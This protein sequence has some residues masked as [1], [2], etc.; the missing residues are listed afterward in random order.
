M[1][2]DPKEMVEKL[3]RFEADDA[4][5]DVSKSQTSQVRF[6]NSDI[7]LTSTVYKTVVSVFIARKGRLMGA[8]IEDMSNIDASLRQLVKLSS[9]MAPNRDYRGIAKGKFTYVK[10]EPTASG[11]HENLVDHAHECITSAEDAG[12]KRSAGVVYHSEVTRSL[13]S[14]TGINLKEK[15]GYIEC[16]IRSFVE[17]DASGHGV[18]CSAVPS[19]FSPKKAGEEAAE[20]AKRA[21]SFPRE[22]IQEGKCDVVFGR[23]A[24]ANLIDYV[25]YALSAFSVDAGMSMFKDKVGQHVASNAINLDDNGIHPNGIGS[26]RFDDEGHPTQMTRLIEKGVL[27]SYLHNT[28]T[29]ARYRVKNTG[30]A[31]IISPRHWNLLLHPGNLKDEEIIEGVK[32]GI[33]VTNVWYTRYQNRTTGDFSTIPR[34]AI[35]KIQNGK[36]VGSLKDARV[37][38][39]LINILMSIDSLSREVKQIHWWE[40]ERPVFTPVV[41]VKNVTIT[42]STK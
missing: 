22:S 35:F 19:N 6:A 9:S 17:K 16:S 5:C 10:E 15:G 27:R 24:M 11:M 12:A 20:I 3:L 39:N 40:V 13:S 28:S 38:D 18:S 25:G 36:V 31:G 7:V 42:K 29:A 1:N 34:D 4:I 32:N 41:K 23:L 37:S 26:H 14:S 21:A 2:I 30:N 33:M 8:E